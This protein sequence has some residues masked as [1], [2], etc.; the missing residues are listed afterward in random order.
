MSTPSST[1]PKKVVILGGGLAGLATAFWLTEKP[2]WEREYDITVYQ[3]GWRLGGKCASGRNITPGY[4]HRIEE[5]GLHMFFGFYENAFLTVRRAFDVLRAMPSPPVATFADWREAFRPHTL[6]ILPEYVDGRW[7]KWPIVFPPRP[8]EP[9]TGETPTAW[10]LVRELVAWLEAFYLDFLREQLG[11]ASYRLAPWLPNGVAATLSHAA[12]AVEGRATGVVEWLL[13]GLAADREDRGD[14]QL[15]LATRA[16]NEI[17]R[18]IR[19]A[20]D[21]LI[22]GDDVIRRIAGRHLLPAWTLDLVAA[23]LDDRYGRADA[24]LLRILRAVADSLP[25]DPAQHDCAVWEFLADTMQAFLDLALN[26]LEPFAR[27]DDMARRVRFLLDLGGTTL[28]GLMRDRV[29]TRGF[30][31]F[32]DEEFRAWLRRHG[33]RQETLDSRLLLAW[34]DMAFA[35]EGG[36]VTR[37]NAAAGT[38]L[39]GMLRLLF[40]YKGSFAYKM[41]AGMGDTICTPLFGVLRARGVRFEF[42][43]RVDRLRLDPFDKTIIDQVQLTRQVDLT[44]DAKRNG[45]NPLVRVHDLDCWPSEPNLAQIANAGAV[46]AHP[47]YPFYLE[48]NRMPWPSTTPQVVLRRG[49]D[50]DQVVLAIPVGA[51]ERI[52]PDLEAQDVGW[53]RMLRGDAA[54]ATPPVG[55]VRTQAVQLWLQPLSGAAARRRA[56]LIRRSGWEPTR[57]QAL[58]GGYA[59]PFDTWSDMSQL[60]RAESW[61]PAMCG[62]ILYSC[63]PMLEEAG[64]EPSDPMYLVQQRD[65]VHADARQ[66]LLQQWGPLWPEFVT[67]PAVPAGQWGQVLVDPGSGA[68][69][70]LDRQYY[71]ANVDPSERY[72]ACF[73]RTTKVRLP[74]EGSGFR[75]LVLAGD[76]ILNP[77]LSA[78]AAEPT[79]ASGMAAA[80]AISGYPGVIYGEG[81]ATGL[82]GFLAVKTP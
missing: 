70:A 34:Y 81:L 46:K 42:F 41:Q 80:R 33:A 52:C 78:G 43:H 62:S 63:G 16:A 73:A 18:L 21:P 77:V 31:A 7:S 4:G 22:G 48:S 37:P 25:D 50:F 59:E 53:R 55:T 66:W 49:V 47:A 44:Q 56:T 39:L 1:P 58:T 68:G 79:I 71:R 67:R 76:W 17:L 29:L 19:C 30:A 65:R 72:V 32:D 14:R 36:D 26:V 57:H 10:Q 11:L 40:G 9:G 75:N 28:I 12:H 60:V 2:G 8:G 24:S 20:L 54:T 64:P 3:M 27:F 51:L 38:A 13:P 74:A 69:D 45:Y 61:P 82:K 6:A 5:H 15:P 35:F 23:P